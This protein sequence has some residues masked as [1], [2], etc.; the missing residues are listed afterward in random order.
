MLTATEILLKQNKIGV[1]D[2]E[3]ESLETL[4][5]FVCSKKV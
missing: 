3:F 1:Q 5:S 4:L 2:T